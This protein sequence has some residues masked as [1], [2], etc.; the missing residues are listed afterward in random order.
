[1]NTGPAWQKGI[2]FG[3]ALGLAFIAFF[4]AFLGLLGVWAGLLGGIICGIGF[5]RYATGYAANTTKRP[6]PSN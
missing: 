4:G 6:P 1:M 5:H 2:L 3:L